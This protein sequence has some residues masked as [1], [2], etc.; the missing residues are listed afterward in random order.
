MGCEANSGEFA[1]DVRRES[2]SHGR[3][4]TAVVR[5]IALSGPLST[6]EMETIESRTEWSLYSAAQALHREPQCA[7]QVLAKSAGTVCLSNVAP[8]EIPV[9]FTA[10]ARDGRPKRCSTLV[11][12]PLPEIYIVLEQTRSRCVSAEEVQSTAPRRRYRW[13]GER[14]A[15]RRRWVACTLSESHKAR[16]E[17]TAGG[18]S[19]DSK[20]KTAA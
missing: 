11:F 1:G 7:L 2:S 16:R 14:P 3:N 4:G 10:P 18:R 6:S 15:R 5:R 17:D 12:F 13:E 8:Q 9:Y 19:G 20:L